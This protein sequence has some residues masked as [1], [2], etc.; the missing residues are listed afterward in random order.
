MTSNLNKKIA[1]GGQFFLLPTLLYDCVFK[2]AF[3]FSFT[4]DES[5]DGCTIKK[6][7]SCAKLFCAH[8]FSH[9]GL[10]AIL[11]SINSKSM[12]VTLQIFIISYFVP[13][14]KVQLQPDGCF[15]LPPLGV[16]L[17]AGG[18]GERE[19]GEIGHVREALGSHR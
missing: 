7:K 12:C 5:E 6:V 11:V 18:A 13:I 14:P 3:R 16:P 19:R 4:S 10:S 17:R 9:V 15:P 8:L 2:H 1:R